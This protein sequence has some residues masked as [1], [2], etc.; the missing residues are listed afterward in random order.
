M[1][2]WTLEAAEQICVKQKGEFD[3]LDVLSDLIDKSLVIMDGSPGEARYHLLET[4][5]QY[6]DEKL[7]ESKEAESS[8]T[9][10]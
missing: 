9:S 3:V 2:G 6:A 10:I 8:V 7:L 4:T 1:G 5:R